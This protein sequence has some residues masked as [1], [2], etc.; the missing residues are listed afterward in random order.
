MINN[1]V[2]LSISDSFWN[3]CNGFENK[4]QL[5]EKAKYILEQFAKDGYARLPTV[6]E[7][8]E[9]YNDRS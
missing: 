1:K 2:E 6:A 3:H 5:E 9:D 4:L 7:L 8:I